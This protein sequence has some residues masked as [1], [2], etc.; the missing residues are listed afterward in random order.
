MAGVSRTIFADGAAL[1]RLVH[2]V[3]ALRLGTRGH[4][5]QHLPVGL[6]AAPL[7]GGHLEQ[8]PMVRWRAPAFTVQSW[9][10]PPEMCGED[11]PVS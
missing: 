2:G 11:I 8:K 4:G 7:A 5:A 6:A 10:L 3:H 9:G 1:V